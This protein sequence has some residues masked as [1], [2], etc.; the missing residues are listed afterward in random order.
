MQQKGTVASGWFS[1]VR[2]LLRYDSNI[3]IIFLSTKVQRSP[4]MTFINGH[5]LLTL[6]VSFLLR[7]HET[8]NACSYNC[9]NDWY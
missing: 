9:R 5:D 2:S 3:N 4:V 1:Q 8:V 7:M 6:N